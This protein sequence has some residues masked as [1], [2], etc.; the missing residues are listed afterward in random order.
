MQANSH[1]KCVRGGMHTVRQWLEPL[2]LSQYAEVFERNHV[3]WELLENL[4]I[5]IF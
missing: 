1:A 3:G 4:L 2:G 5:K